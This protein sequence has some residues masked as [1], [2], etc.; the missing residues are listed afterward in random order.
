MSIC[1]TLQNDSNSE[2]CLFESCFDSPFSNNM[3]ES[4]ILPYNG[5][6]SKESRNF[7]SSD[8]DEEPVMS[9]TLTIILVFILHASR[10]PSRFILRSLAAFLMSFSELNTLMRQTLL[11]QTFFTRWLNSSSVSRT[12]LMYQT[13]LPSR[14]SMAGP[15]V[16]CRRPY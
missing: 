14:Y 13:F 1:L 3:L 7:F 6:K 10:C 9:N 2:N 4:L 8:L 15:S 16:R 12:P 5:K 11:A